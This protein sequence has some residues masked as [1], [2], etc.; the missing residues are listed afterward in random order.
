MDGTPRVAKSSGLPCMIYQ[1]TVLPDSGSDL[2]ENQVVNVDKGTFRNLTRL[3]ELNLARNSLRSLGKN[4]FINAS[5]HLQR[6]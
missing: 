2:S 3:T 5:R 4:F 1:A 6:L